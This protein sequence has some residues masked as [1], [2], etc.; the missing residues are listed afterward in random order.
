LK[1]PFANVFEGFLT[2]LYA[3]FNAFRVIYCIYC[4][5]LP[6]KNHIVFRECHAP[7][8]V[9]RT[10]SVYKP[11]LFLTVT[12]TKGYFL[13]PLPIGFTFYLHRTSLRSVL[14]MHK[15]SAMAVE[16]GL[17]AKGMTFI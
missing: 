17:V 13:A 6:K 11:V 5:L 1:I 16:L 8:G 10:L 3:Y 12:G 2:R 9:G 14:K 15:E 4:H 7:P